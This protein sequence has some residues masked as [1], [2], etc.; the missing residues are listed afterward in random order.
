MS[1]GSDPEPAFRPRRQAGYAPEDPEPMLSWG[2]ILPR[3]LFA[4]PA[5]ILAAVLLAMAFG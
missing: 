1:D 2:A 5:I 4:L 3:L